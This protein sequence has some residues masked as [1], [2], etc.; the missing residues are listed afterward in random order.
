MNDI[1]IPKGK[2]KRTIVSTKTAAKVGG[3][4]LTYLA[5]KP[6][7]SKDKNAFAKKE[8]SEK[9]AKAIFK[10]LTLLKGT[11]LK[12]AQFLSMELEML[13]ETFR[14]ELEKSYNKVPP[15]NRAIVRKI[16]KDVY[17]DS[18]ENVFKN[19]E[20]LAFAA[21]SLG[22]VHLA[23]TKQG[24]KIAL[25]IQYPGIKN[26][27]ESDLKL[28]RTVIRPFPDYA[29]LL[30]GLDEVEE[31]LIEETDYI[32]EGKNLL[33]FKKHLKLKSVRI[34]ILYDD[35]NSDV[36]IA[37]EYMEGLA[38]N[39][40]IKTN[41]SIQEKNKIGKVLYDIFIKS[42]YELKCIHA[43]PNP[44]NFIIMPDLKIGL[45]DFGCIKKFDP[46]FIDNYQKLNK[47][48]LSG[49]AEYFNILEDLNLFIKN[50]SEEV[51]ND[52]FQIMHKVSKWYGRFYKEE[53]FDF[54]KNKDTFIEPQ[55]LFKELAKY[56]KY[57]NSQPDFI[58]LDRTRYGLYRI[59]EQM[60]V[61]IKIRNTY[62]WDEKNE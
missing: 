43:D 15:L 23:K 22:Q 5:K 29:F 4:V 13:P 1:E 32:N 33:F 47:A 20:G 55:Q 8:L 60:Q 17:E 14:K 59:F 45:I 52:I 62:E 41:P 26:T 46:T 3:K 44:G 38:L 2:F 54:K 48:I 7:L 53:M 10:S 61:K 9:S 51:K 28:V 12:I 37:T 18:P 36:V 35:Y 27:I 24:N 30:P 50:I 25:K 19:F 57:F 58:Y 31:K 34:P 49:K 16:L 42:L 39:E 6:F 11:A 40:W 56:K 21:A